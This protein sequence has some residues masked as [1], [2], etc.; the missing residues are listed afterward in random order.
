MTELVLYSEACKALEAAKNTDEAKEIR[1]KAEAMRAY[2]RQAR[3][4]QLE[5]DAAEIRMRAERRLG[6]IIRAQKETVGLNPGVRMA[7]KDSLGG[8]VVEPPKPVPTLADAGIDKK[9]SSRAQKMAAV[10]ADKFEGMVSE[11]R[12]RIEK[13]NER[14]TTNILKAGEKAQKREEKQARK[15]IDGRGT[16]SLQCCDI[17]EF[18]V[19][20]A[21][22]DWI[23]T[24]PPYPKEHLACWSYLAEFS[25]HALK[26][27]GALLAMS[28]QSYLP[29]VMD[30]L[31]EH[32]E[33]YWT[34]AYL[35]PGGQ[36][37]GIFHRKVNTFW[38]PIFWFVK[39]GD[40]YARD[41]VGDV[42]KSAVNDNDKRFHHWGQSESGMGDLIERFT[43]PGDIICDPFLGGGTTGLVAVDMGR[44]FIGCD[45]DGNCVEASRERIAA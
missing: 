1:D 35:T 17:R 2:A 10:P 12:G 37:T 43:D 42:V 18:D 16:A 36:S 7:G 3:N 23:I 26:D 27:G 40:K 24:D 41:R 32:L 45:I 21:S 44:N 8:A 13:E 14:V 20:A 34:L 38:K 22:V 19:P 4:K 28:G 30:A 39:K 15:K 29:Q 6:E 5:I 33:Y 25:A 9:L 11:W 31:C